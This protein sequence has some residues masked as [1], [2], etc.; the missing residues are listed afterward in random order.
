MKKLIRSIIT[1]LVIVSSTSI[2]FVS[3][4]QAHPWHD[5]CY[6]LFCVCI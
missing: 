4:A 1:A 5:E 3:Q 6:G 2:V